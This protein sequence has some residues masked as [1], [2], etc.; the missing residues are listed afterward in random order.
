PVYNRIKVRWSVGTRGLAD[1]ISRSPM[2]KLSLFLGIAFWFPLMNHSHAADFSVK[3]ADKE[4]PNQI[5]ES[6]RKALQPKSVQLL[7]GDKP[8]FEFWF[9]SE[10]SL[11]SKP[12]S[13]DKALGSIHE[14]TL[15]GAV[16]VGNGQRD[17]KDNEIAA[18]V[19]T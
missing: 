12:G 13:A 6:I 14:T 2:N 18:G 3:V 19:Y 11:K 17:Y 16:S 9:G 8:V 4:P 15:L 1:S 5:G 7:N 10:V